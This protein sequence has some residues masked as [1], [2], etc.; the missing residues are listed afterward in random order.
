MGDHIVIKVPEQLDL[1]LSE[2][3][4]S[5]DTLINTILHIKDILIYL[6]N[7]ELVPFLLD[8]LP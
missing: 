3:P 8:I 4:P 6:Y 5:L 7:R 1:E 2:V